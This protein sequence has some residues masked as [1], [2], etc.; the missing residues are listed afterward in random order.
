[1][2]QQVRSILVQHPAPIEI[3][4]GDD[5]SSDDTVAVIERTV[6]DARAADPSLRISLTIHRRDEPLGVVGNFAATLAACGGD[7]VALSD[8]DDIWAPDKL[9]RI[10]PRFADDPDLLLVHTDA[11][12]VDGSGEPLGLGLLDALEATPGE[13][14]GLEWGDAFGV[15]MRRNLVTGATVVARRSLVARAAPFPATWIHDEWLAVLA[16]ALGRLRLDPEQLIDYRQHGANVIG[17]RRPTMED[18]MRKL[19]EPRAERASWLIERSNALVERLESLDA[20]T[21]RLAAAR[22]K[23]AHETARAR[24]PRVRIA[25]LPGVLAGAISGRYSRYSRGPIDILRDLVQPVGGDREG[26]HT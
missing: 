12:L 26:E 18:R 22:G 10:V 14:S 19:R 24:L 20:P 2:G 17:A 15:L 3:V 16:A 23:L 5:A 8:Q 6:A 9:A 11:R 13:R 7:L 4:V 21:R 25:R 1:V